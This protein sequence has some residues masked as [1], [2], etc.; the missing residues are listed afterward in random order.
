MMLNKN[1]IV[2]VV[3]DGMGNDGEGIA[4]VDG[5]TLFIKDA[6][7]GDK[8]VVK[9]IKAKKKYGYARVEEIIE[10]AI[11]RVEP[12]CPVARQCGGCQLQHINYERQLK[13]KE[14]KVK[15]CIERIGGIKGAKME[16]I[17]GM[18]ELYNYRN[19]A[20]FPVGLDKD[21]NIAIGFYAKRS[22][23][24]I[25]NNKCYI[26]DR[27]NET[28]ISV[29]KEF[30]TDNN[31][32]PYDETTGKGL[33]RHVVTRVGYHTKEV[34]VCL[35]INADDMKQSLKN[36]L[37]T[38]LKEISNMKSISLNVNKENTNVI[39]GKKLISVYGNLYITDYL[40]GIKFR[41][42][43]L[44]FYQVNPRQTEKLY[45]IALD[46]ANI[47]NNEIVWDMYCGIGTISLFMAS[48]AKKVYGVEIVPEAIEDAK[49]NAT[50]NCIDNAEFYV[51]A[52]EEVVPKMYEKSHGKMKA[53]VVVVDPPR[54][55]CDEKLLN[56]LVQMEPKRIVY[57]SCDP[58]TLARDLKWLE[59]NGYKTVKYRA[60][61]QFGMTTH[62]ETVSLLQ[63][64]DV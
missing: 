63:K 40:E 56:T 59:D 58:A 30:I 38:R 7:E 43:P 39:M 26:N 27:I 12:I 34:M 24:I 25:P 13:Y 6:V 36:D 14:N 64:R 15:D 2:E 17:L 52:A 16:P 50:L 33:I 46:Y 10:S 1:D 11:D 3:I 57:V 21:G 41:I 18:E 37:V 23:T 4:H 55:G 8:L 35:V 32:Q 62:V 48:K 5:Y 9:V 47:N 54:K 61:D 44:S 19:K 31:V 45:N 51:G 29:I 60:V 49:L 28:I 42:S 20:Q 22:H 53:D